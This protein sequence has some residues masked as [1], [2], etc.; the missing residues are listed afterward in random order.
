MTVDVLKHHHL[1]EHYLPTEAVRVRRRKVAIVGFDKKYYDPDGSLFESSFPEYKVEPIIWQYE[2]LS[3][4][5][6]GLVQEAGEDGEPSQ[7]SGDDNG[8]EGKKD[9]E[10]VESVDSPQQEK[11]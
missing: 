2:R 7:T 4:S 9:E 11:E 5:Y 3:I 10:T 8:M 6:E 1:P